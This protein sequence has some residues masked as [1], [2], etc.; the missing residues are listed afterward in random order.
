MKKEHSK[1][2]SSSKRRKKNGKGKVLYSYCG[3]GFHLESSCMRRQLDEMALL[4]KK[5]NI[6]APTSA[7]KDDS[8]DED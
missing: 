1:E 5:H 4:L 8:E 6:S 3:R 7:R 2:P